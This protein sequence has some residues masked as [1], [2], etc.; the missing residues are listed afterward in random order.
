MSK[1]LRKARKSPEETFC[2][3]QLLSEVANLR[4]SEQFEQI[5]RL[6]DCIYQF[7]YIVID[8]TAAEKAV[9]NSLFC[10]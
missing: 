3:I 10:A 4:F 8:T 6:I 1:I 5:N 7:E 2:H 9:L